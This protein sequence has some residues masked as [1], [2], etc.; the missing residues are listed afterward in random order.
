MYN[1]LTPSLQ[2]TVGCLKELLGGFVSTGGKP[3]EVIHYLFPQFLPYLVTKTYKMNKRICPSP[4]NHPL[5]QRFNKI[6]PT[7][8][9]WHLYIGVTYLGQGMGITAGALMDVILTSK[10]PGAV[11]I[12]IGEGAGIKNLYDI[13]LVCYF[14]Q[15]AA[16]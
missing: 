13:N 14:R 3:A 15:D 10:V 16:F 9:L 8:E 4:A 2:A 7:V 6:V 5:S 12:L 11:H 1:G